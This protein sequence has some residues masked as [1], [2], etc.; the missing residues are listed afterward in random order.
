VPYP[1][2]EEPIEMPLNMLPTPVYGSEIL[3]PVNYPTRFQ[4][5]MLH[6]LV[7]VGALVPVRPNARCIR[8]GRVW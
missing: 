6:L 8:C 1:I 3:R 2:V 7:L 4:H 5:A